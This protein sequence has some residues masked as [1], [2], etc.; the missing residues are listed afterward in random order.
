MR[1]FILED[2]PNR[3]VEFHKWFDHHS[4]EVTYIHTCERVEE[5]Q[6]PYDYLFLD[7]D[8][9]GS[10]LGYKHGRP[11]SLQEAEDCG[12]TF[13]K[14]I[15]E[16]LQRHQPEGVIIHSYNPDGARNM[17]LELRG[18][19]KKHVATLPFG[20]VSFMNVIKG[21]QETCG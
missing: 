14:L 3:I 13:V 2:D 21:I 17:A 5:F 6:P 9:G 1:I 12:L 10:Q 19:V 18:W 16:K 7:H 4:I 11:L 20:K 8:L 15:G